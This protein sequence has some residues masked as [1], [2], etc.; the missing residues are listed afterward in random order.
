MP[1]D[2]K[3]LAE[4]TAHS[5][6][7]DEVLGMWS[8]DWRRAREAFFEDYRLEIEAEPRR[9]RRGLRKANAVVRTNTMYTALTTATA[10]S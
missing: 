10:L 4:E 6:D 1:A 3:K 8:V 9:F 7:P 5:F 2:W